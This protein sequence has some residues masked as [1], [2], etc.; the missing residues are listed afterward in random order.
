MLLEDKQK[1][2]QFMKHLNENSI[3]CGIH[4]PIPI[5]K[6]PFYKKEE[7]YLKRTEDYA[8]RIVSLPIHPFLKQQELEKIVHTIN[9]FN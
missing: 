1:R 9:N 8:D 6:M 5:H 4:Y 7:L 3:Q 2:N